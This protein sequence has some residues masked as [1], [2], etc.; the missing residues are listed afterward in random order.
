MRTDHC[1]DE[2]ESDEAFTISKSGIRKWIERECAE[3]NT[4]DWP[5]IDTVSWLGTGAS[6]YTSQTTVMYT[7]F[8]E[9]WN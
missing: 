3:N 2:I 1:A 9:F 7:F 8:Y 6:E 4:S 5:D